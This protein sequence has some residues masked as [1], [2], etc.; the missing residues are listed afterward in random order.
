MTKPPKPQE[1]K[2]PK[3]TPAPAKSPPAGKGKKRAAVSRHRLPHARAGKRAK[4]RHRMAMTQA[5]RKL[6]L[7]TLRQGRTVQSGADAAGVDRSTVYLIRKRDKDFEKLWDDAYETGTDRV[8]EE[9]TRRA[10]VGYKK[11]V[12]VKVGRYNAEGKRVGEDV[13]A[14]EETVFS[15]RLMEIMMR[16]RRPQKFRERVDHTH[17]GKKGAPPIAFRDV[18][19]KDLSNEQISDLKQRIVAGPGSEAAAPAGGH[20]APGDNRG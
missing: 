13:V 20:S 9:A 15:D 5:Q 8:E 17:A 4:R 19:V 14:R 12:F 6:F 7:D 10:F 11:P 1:T 18:S 3:G 16:A 2:G